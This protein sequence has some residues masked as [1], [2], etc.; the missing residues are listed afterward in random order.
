MYGVPLLMLITILGF[1]LIEAIASFA[2]MMAFLV[3]ILD[4]GYPELAIHS[5]QQQKAK[6]SALTPPDKLWPMLSFRMNQ[7]QSHP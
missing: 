4:G 7:S 2:T 5:C 3:T 6:P 1:A